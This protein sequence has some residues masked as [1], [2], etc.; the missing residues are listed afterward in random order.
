MA[1][2]VLFTVIG[3]VALALEVLLLPLTYFFDKH[4]TIAS[5]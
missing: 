5:E 4:S 2:L 3:L 1:M